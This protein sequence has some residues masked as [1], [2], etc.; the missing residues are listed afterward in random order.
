MGTGRERRWEVKRRKRR[1]NQRPL[2]GTFK[3]DSTSV[4]G[5]DPNDIRYVAIHE[6]GHAVSAVVLGF[7]L[8]SVEIRRRRM[9]SGQWSLGFTDTGSVVNLEVAGKGEEF[10]KS[11]LIQEF[12]GPMA[13]LQVNDR[14]A[15][16]SALADDLEGARRIAVL[17]ICEASDKG[18]GT[19]EINPNEM[20]RNEARLNS[21]IRN[22]LEATNLLIKDHW[23]AICRVADLLVTRKVLTGDEVATIVNAARNRGSR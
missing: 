15:E 5:Y 10:V 6:A 20:A 13:E 17:A 16:S 4:D 18:D 8:K 22:A 2:R 12:S 19:F 14:A 3:A 23:S 11:Y 9:P 7:N 1:F 21:L